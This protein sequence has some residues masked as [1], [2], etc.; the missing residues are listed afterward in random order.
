MDG[1][2]SVYMRRCIELALKAEGMT[3]PNPVVGAVVVWKGRIIGEGY[4]RGAGLPHAEV[5]AIESVKNKSL[6][7]ESVLYVSLEPCSHH[8]KTPPCT[9]LIISS[10]IRK[11]VAGTT[12]TSS[13]VSG[14]GFRQLREAGITVETG[15]LGEECRRINRRFF[16]FHEAARPYIIL[17]WAQSAD[18]FIDADRP[19]GSNREAWWITGMPERVLVHKWRSEED[20]ILVGG[21]TVR[22]DNPG[23]DVRHWHGK[24]PVKVI[25]S[26]S[27]RIDGFRPKNETNGMLIAFTYNIGLSI[28]GAEKVILNKDLSTASQ[29][30]NNLHQ[31]GFQSL[32]VEGGAKVLSHFI[33][34]GLWDEARV[35]TG[36]REF[37]SGV[38]APSVAGR[39]ILESGFDE[40]NLE[41]T[42]NRLNGF[43]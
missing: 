23:L 31:R 43:Y 6:L 40:S 19:S 30:V 34:T 15:L 29:V 5:N 12:D 38:P 18:G 16:T 39:K 33:G 35:F 41:I 14:N 27:G 13:K 21:E 10:G 37:C 28:P 2:S 22:N 4:H 1:N 7:P 3:R 11:V 26:G 20:T 17:K 42:V 32:F 25:V 36:K 9:Q 8:G 24:N